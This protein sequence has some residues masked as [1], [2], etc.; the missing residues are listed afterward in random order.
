MHSVSDNSTTRQSIGTWR[1]LRIL[2]AFATLLTGVVVTSAA[3]PAAAA[4]DP[5]ICYIV[6][7]GGGGNGG[8]DRL[9]TFDRSSG[10][11]A[12]VG[13]GTGTYDIEAADLWP[14]TDTLYA[15]NADELGTI[16]L[17]HRGVHHDRPKVRF[18][19][20]CRRRAGR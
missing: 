11:F 16:N 5:N 15:I 9:V 10:V 12:P 7:D 13:A 1:S 19:E 2:I 3:T 17:D 8:N 14:P 4:T 6:A 18:A 20:R